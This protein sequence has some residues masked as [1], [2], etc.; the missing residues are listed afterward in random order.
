MTLAGLSRREITDMTTAELLGAPVEHIV[1]DLMAPRN[2]ASS[3][4]E[5]DW[6]REGE[7]TIRFRFHV[8][9]DDWPTLNDYDWECYGKVAGI[10]RHP[11]RYGCNADRPEGFDGSAEIISFGR[12]ADSCWWQ[13]PEDI[14]HDRE[15]R[16]QMRQTVSDILEYGFVEW[17]VDLYRQ[18]GS[19]DQWEHFGWCTWSGMEPMS[20]AHETDVE[21]MVCEALD[22]IAGELGVMYQ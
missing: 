18:C 6:H 12:S 3:Y 22:N 16:K 4:T 20:E 17:T 15:A 14:A 8:M 13:P 5:Y 9:P 21:N 11:Y 10:E 1:L 2:Y 7:P 19:C